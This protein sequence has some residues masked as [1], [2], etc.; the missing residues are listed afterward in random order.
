VNFYKLGS[1]SPKN[2]KTVP[3]CNCKET[4]TVKNFELLKLLFKRIKKKALLSLLDFYSFTHIVQNIY[5]VQYTVQFVPSSGLSTKFLSGLGRPGNKLFYFC[6]KQRKQLNCTALWSHWSKIKQIK[7]L[8][9][10]QYTAT[11]TGTETEETTF[12]I[13]TL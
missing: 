13:H 9:L 4:C 2:G 6:V 7:I 11:G 3:S 8:I 5:R 1:A 12:K 10:Y